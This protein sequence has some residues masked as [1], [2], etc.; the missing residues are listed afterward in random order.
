LFLLSEEFRPNWARL[1]GVF[2]C[3]EVWSELLFDIEIMANG[4]LDRCSK[5]EMFWK[6]SLLFVE[7]RFWRE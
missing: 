4:L 5:V 1:K 2:S 6:P 7:R 3:D